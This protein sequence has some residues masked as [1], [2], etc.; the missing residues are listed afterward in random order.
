[1]G[2]KAPRKSLKT[3]TKS[4]RPPAPS[5]PQLSP[6]WS[7]WHHSSCWVGHGLGCRRYSTL[8]LAVT[9]DIRHQPAYIR[10]RQVRA[11]QGGPPLHLRPLG[12]YSSGARGTA[13]VG[14]GALGPSINELID[15]TFGCCR[16]SK[17]ADA[18]PKGAPSAGTLLMHFKCSNLPELCTP[19]QIS[20]AP[21]RHMGGRWWL[22]LGRDLAYM[23][24]SICHWPC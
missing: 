12:S 22:I 4:S 18:M 11:S 1:M 15:T 10:P 20:S 19:R 8:S 17:A 9:N 13:A 24:I 3:C 6:L 7:V 14:S 5:N 23:G 21:F 2:H 16:S